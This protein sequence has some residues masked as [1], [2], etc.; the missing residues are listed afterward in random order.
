MNFFDDETDLTICEP[1]DVLVEIEN[2][3]QRHSDD[4]GDDDEEEEVDE[5]DDD[6]ED[7]SG[8][9]EETDLTPMM[10]KLA[11]LENVDSIGDEGTNVNNFLNYW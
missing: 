11:E 1:P 4:G 5:D 3:L 2:I 7:D 6:T 9:A 10:K 8:I